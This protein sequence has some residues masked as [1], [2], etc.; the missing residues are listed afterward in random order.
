MTLILNQLLH[1]ISRR[2][3]CCNTGNMASCTNKNCVCVFVYC[4][5]HLLLVRTAKTTKLRAFTKLPGCNNTEKV[6]LFLLL[7]SFL[8]LSLRRPVSSLTTLFSSGQALS[9]VLLQQPEL[10]A[11]WCFSPLFSV[12]KG[13]RSNGVIP[14][15]SGKYFAT[16]VIVPRFL[17]L[18]SRKESPNVPNWA[19]SPA[20]AS[21]LSKRTVSKVYPPSCRHSQL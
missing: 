18:F 11:L 10:L 13:L 19:I 15:G 17:N 8:F 16:L 1:P 3:S 6:L 14:F 21:N 12:G 9:P 7:F 4:C 5:P 20:S 2:I